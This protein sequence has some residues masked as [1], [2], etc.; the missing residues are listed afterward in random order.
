MFSFAR[1]VIMATDLESANAGLLSSSS[2]FNNDCLEGDGLIVVDETKRMKDGRLF[3][4]FLLY[5]EG[6]EK[7]I[8]RGFIHLFAT[9]VLPFG[10]WHLNRE[11]NGNKWGLIAST[12]YII[13]NIWCYGFSALY[14]VGKW[15]PK[16]EIFLQKLDHC[17]IALLSMGTFLPVG[18]LLFP[19]GTGVVFIV[20][21]LS[22]SLWACWNIMHTRP[23]VIRQALVPCVSLVFIPALYVHLT[24]F[25]FICYLCTILL[26]VLGMFV[27][28][29]S[30]PNPLPRIFGY[31]EL[32][33]VFVVAAGVVV[34]LCNWSVVR[35]VCNPYAHSQDVIADVFSFF[36]SLGVYENDNSYEVP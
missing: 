28:I 24:T 25:E 1:S 2:S 17:G 7:P 9:I 5:C 11:S 14:H 8:C 35:R 36:L 32:F 19:L 16:V 27:F 22:T 33:H 18:I 4:D 30:W 31:H 12:V 34:Y 26:Q 6:L 20:M 10:M 29:S 21:L 3:P 13:T 23:S 15:S